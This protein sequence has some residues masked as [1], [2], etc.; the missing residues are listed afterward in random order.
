MNYLASLSISRKN[1]WIT[2]HST[3]TISTLGPG[4]KSA[5]S[6]SNCL[7]VVIL[8]WEPSFACHSSFV[9]SAK[10]RV[11]AFTPVTLLGLD[12]FPFICHAQQNNWRLAYTNV[13]RFPAQQVCHWLG[14]CSIINTLLK[15]SYPSDLEYYQW[16]VTS[17]SYSL[18]Q[19]PF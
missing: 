13:A 12:S 15:H 7:A 14:S 3:L 4:K 16:I 18:G 5:G 19:I 10:P 6:S 11:L 2:V 1:Y 9:V 8:T 17:G